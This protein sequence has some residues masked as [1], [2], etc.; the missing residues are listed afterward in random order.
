VLLV[1]VFGPWYFC[2]LFGPRSRPWPRTSGLDLDLGLELSGLGLG[3]LASASR[4]LA[5]LTS[6]QW[7]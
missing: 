4:C 6:L 5:L 7:V 1:V 2:T 3:P